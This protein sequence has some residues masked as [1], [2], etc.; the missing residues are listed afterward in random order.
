MSNQRKTP[1]VGIANMG[2]TCYMNAVL[3]SLMADRS[4]IAMIDR[5]LK[6]YEPMSITLSEGLLAMFS[7]RRLP[8]VDVLSAELIGTVVAARNPL[9]RTF[10]QQDAHEFLTLFMELL[11][12]EFS[13]RHPECRR[14]NELKARQALNSVKKPHETRHAHR[15]K[16][17][18]ILAKNGKSNTASRR[19]VRNS[20]LENVS[21][22]VDSSPG[23][24][25]SLQRQFTCLSCGGRS[26]PRKERQLGISVSIPEDPTKRSDEASRQVCD[27]DDLVWNCFEPDVIERTC[28]YCRSS[29]SVAETSVS[30]PPR[31]LVVH[32]KRFTADGRKL[33]TLVKVPQHLFMS[34]AVLAMFGQPVNYQLF[35][36]VRHSSTSCKS[37][38][39]TADV[40]GDDG[41]W[42]H[43][44][45]RRISPRCL[46]DLQ[47]EQ[48][49]L[50]FYKTKETPEV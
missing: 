26:K 29:C 22:S 16:A 20:S 32:L 44:N 47:D 24:Y 17:C 36:V 38:H 35:A 13:G 5:R 28:E 18:K 3:Q 23:Y 41:S 43:C 12:K 27:L 9:F 48:G 37:G 46:D 1:I 49:Y 11:Y 34:P 19:Q 33:D 2:N 6:A 21:R 31:C 7:S 14:R 15:L 4:L 45:D 39:Y 40:L 42:T 50:Y 25:L 8:R 30:Q 10:E